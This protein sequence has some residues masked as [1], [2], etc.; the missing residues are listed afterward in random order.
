VGFN[1][2]LTF[3]G[4]A[5]LIWGA[6][7]VRS[8]FF[9]RWLGVLYAVAGGCYLVNALA[10]FVA[11]GLPVFPWILYPCLV[12]EGAVTLWLIVVGVD[13]TKWRAAAAR[14]GAP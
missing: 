1:I 4:F 5:L 8:G 13:E 14:S 3:F 10:S 7:I 6:L 2:G 12:G 9:P 11:P